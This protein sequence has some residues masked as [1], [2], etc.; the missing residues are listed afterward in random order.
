MRS[1]VAG[2]PPQETPTRRVAPEGH[3]WRRHRRFPEGAG[4]PLSGRAALRRSGHRESACVAPALQERV[5]IRGDRIDLEFA[6]ASVVASVAFLRGFGTMPR[7]YADTIHRPKRCQSA[8]GTV[9][10]SRIRGTWA[11]LPPLA[12][13]SRPE[14]HE[15]LVGGLDVVRRAGEARLAGQAGTGLVAGGAVRGEVRGAGGGGRDAAPGADCEVLCRRR[16]SAYSAA[17]S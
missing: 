12:A 5:D 13:S 9:S 3:W 8:S 7:P 10:R 1:R 16:R 6:K 11:A 2:L 15:S 14:K 4:Q 17:F